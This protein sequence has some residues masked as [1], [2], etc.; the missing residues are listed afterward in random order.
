MDLGA[1]LR[2]QV[3]HASGRSVQGHPVVSL[4]GDASNRRSRNCI[5]L[6]QGIAIGRERAVLRFLG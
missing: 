6:G 4:K 2:A 5:G 1:A 3:E